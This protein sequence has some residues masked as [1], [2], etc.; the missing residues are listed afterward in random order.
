MTNQSKEWEDIM[1]S[2]QLNLWHNYCDKEMECE[3]LK[4][5]LTEVGVEL[6]RIY[7]HPDEVDYQKLEIFL[8]KIKEVINGS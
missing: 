3:D 6:E 2:S 4:G 7:N 5:L 8:G 1:K